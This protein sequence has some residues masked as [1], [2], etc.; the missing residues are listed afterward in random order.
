MAKKR[1]PPPSKACTCCGLPSG[2]CRCAGMWAVKGIVLLVLGL[3]LWRGFLSLELTI[4]II[5]VLAG[6]KFLF[7]PLWMAK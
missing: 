1:T 6:L 3:A 7:K 5:L 4:A 2:K